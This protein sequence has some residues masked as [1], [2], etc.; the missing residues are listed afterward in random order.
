MRA[1]G[2]HRVFFEI[3]V[4]IYVVVVVVFIKARM[5]RL[6]EKNWTFTCTFSRFISLTL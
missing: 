4:S 1:V 2:Y 5:V 6:G 3:N